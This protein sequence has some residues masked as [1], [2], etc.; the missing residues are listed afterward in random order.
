MR[1]TGLKW[2]LHEYYLNNPRE[3]LSVCIFETHHHFSMRQ[4]HLK[5]RSIEYMLW[6]QKHTKKDKKS[7]GGE[8]PASQQD[9]R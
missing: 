3:I 8:L 4:S 5:V 2:K 1:P 6:L 9:W 7:N